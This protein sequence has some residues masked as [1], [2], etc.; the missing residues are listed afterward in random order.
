MKH[1]LFSLL[2]AGGAIWQ[3]AA[4]QSVD[5]FVSPHGRDSWSG[6]AKKPVATLE[7]ARQLARLTADT[8]SVT[9]WLAD[10]TYYLPSTLTFTPADGKTYPA[11]VSYRACHTGRAIVSG[12]QRL[13]LRW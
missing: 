7:R 1:I 10:G 8:V 2:M 9:V 4:A 12:G 13:E 3:T 6:T 11:T 5:I